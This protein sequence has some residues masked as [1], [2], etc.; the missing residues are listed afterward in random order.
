[1][2]GST[3]ETQIPHMGDDSCVFCVAL[4]V[5][6]RISALSSD[7]YQFLDQTIRRAPQV[8]SRLGEIDGVKLSYFVPTDRRLWDRI[9][10]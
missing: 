10:G 6:L 9:G 2:A 4:F 1:M 7:G 8:E 3:D 5:G